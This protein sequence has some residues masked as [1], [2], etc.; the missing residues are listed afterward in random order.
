ML[1]YKIL[2][3]P[4][5]I[6]RHNPLPPSRPVDSKQGYIIWKSKIGNRQSLL[7]HSLKCRTN[8]SS[9]YCPIR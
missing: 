5:E 4:G 2:L 3:I 7:L 8:P 9:S 6:K 1:L